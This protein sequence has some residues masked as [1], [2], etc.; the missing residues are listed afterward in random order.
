MS[1]QV[2]TLPATPAAQPSPSASDDG[3][4]DDK[5]VVSANEVERNFETGMTPSG[6][7]TGMLLLARAPLGPSLTRNAPV[8]LN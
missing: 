3:K 2:D 1:A 7:T 8:A 6:E 4:Y 5:A